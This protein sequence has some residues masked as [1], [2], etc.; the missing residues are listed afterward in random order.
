MKK[1]TKHKHLTLSQRIEIEKGLGC[2]KSFS[3]IAKEIHK[4]P[5]TVSKEVRKHSKPSQRRNIGFAPIPCSLRKECDLKSLCLKDCGIKCKV[6]REP[7]MRCIDFCTKYKPVICDKLSKP[8][9]VCNNCYKR[10]NCLF[11]KHLYSAKYADDCYRELLVS[12]REGINQTAE[13][14]L[15]MEELI[16]P[17]IKKGQ[18]I[19]HIYAHHAEEI[20]CSRR[21]LY[22]YI[23]QSVFSARN[24]DLRR[25]VK[26]KQRRKSTTCSLKDR[27]FRV[28]RNYEDFQMLL[29]DSP[30]INVV[31]MDTVE[32]TKGG[33][34]LLTLM[35]RNCSLML[36]FLLESKTQEEVLR[37]FN[38]LTNAL[39]DALFH[40]I[41][42]VILTD[43]GTEFQNPT[44]LEYTSNDIRRTNLY[45]CD[46]Y[47]SW[48][49][50]M[51][52]KN[53]E[54]IRHVV[55]KSYTFDFLTQEQVTLM[56]NHI[57]SESRDMLNGCTPFKLSRL[58][59]D[60][61]LHSVL[62]LIEIEPDDVTL[63]PQLLN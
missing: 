38:D 61:K 48:Q 19:A 6:C 30:N 23:D 11:L 42:P 27:N 54:Y 52:E 25:R 47:S 12:S 55:K 29:K 36:A 8:P 1:K 40:Q 35:F 20:G 56:I 16:S 24:L 62:S 32:G 14:I 41:F 57:N 39:G 51:I 49:K 21:T 46:P 59:I 58:L 44:L 34:V 13:S 3:Q 22:H 15:Y 28:G 60:N 50:G 43:G 53:H 18:S 2:G 45:Y 5:S 4:D 33:K 31:E 7:H 17:L 26:Y 10:I 9:Y 63:K 37:V